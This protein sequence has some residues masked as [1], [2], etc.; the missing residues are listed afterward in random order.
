MHARR[1]DAGDAGDVRR[2]APVA[3][4]LALPWGEAGPKRS[5]RESFH[6]PGTLNAWRLG[7]VGRAVVH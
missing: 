3:Q 5:V 2:A 6:A 7:W 1:A 4:R